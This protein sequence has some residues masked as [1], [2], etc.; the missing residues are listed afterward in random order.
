M[1][2]W[3][4][5][6]FKCSPHLKARLP[7]LLNARF[8]SPLTFSVLHFWPAPPSSSHSL[9]RLPNSFLSH[10]I[11][12]FKETIWLKTEIKWFTFINGNL[13]SLITTLS[14]TILMMHILFSTCSTF[15]LPTVH[16]IYGISNLAPSLFFLFQWHYLWN[17]ALW[18]ITNDYDR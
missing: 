3:H 14:Y 16:C 7:H 4:G 6:W 5:K 2:L 11:W 8:L 9:S 15:F 13:S 1:A 17:R 10:N 18:S 12:K